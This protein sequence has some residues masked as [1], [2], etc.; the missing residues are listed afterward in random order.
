MRRASFTRRSLL[1]GGAGALGGALLARAPG[2]AAALTGSAEAALRTYAAGS[3]G[4]LALGQLGPGTHTLELARGASLVGVGWQA[5]RAAP[6]ELRFSTPEGWSAWVQAGERGHGP[7]APAAGTRAVGEPVWTGGSSELQLR[8]GVALRGVSVHTVEVQG[9]P[10][11]GAS[12]AP[13]GARAAALALA[14]P[15]LEAGPGQPPIIARSAW[16][17]GKCPPRAAPGYGAVELAFVHHTDN[18]NGYSAAEVPA[19]LRAIYLFHRY[20]RGWNDIGYN[21]V[22]DLYGRVFEARADGIDEAVVGAQAGGYNLYSSGAAVLGTFSEREISARARRSLQA[23]LSWKLSL[24]G[25]PTQG[26]VVVQVSAAGASYSR[27]P[28]GAQVSLPR[29]AGHREAD[30]TDCPGGVL[31]G[32]LPSIR[33]GAAAQA[34]TPVQA[35]I[36]LVNVPSAQAPPLLEGAAAAGSY[37]FGTLTLLDGTPL[38]GAQVQI[39]ARSVALRGEA[40]SE[41]PLAQATTNEQGEWALPAAPA[42]AQPLQPL[43]ALYAGTPG[44]GGYGA[45]VSEAVHAALA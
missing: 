34:G 10:A 21:F 38:A 36:A 2:S 13:R 33:A 32:Q 41:R 19:M 35:T 8:A 31:Y 39:Q 11:E 12:G 30:Q 1:A 20:V 4:E 27:F 17:R 7:D 6:I 23:L 42:G 24:H 5:P 14:E 3:V 45:T 26:E 44:V 43:R 15:V 22:I 18:P 9:D 40:V 37:L 16:A 25:A 29:I 28:A